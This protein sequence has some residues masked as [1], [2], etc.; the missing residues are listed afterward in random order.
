MD[1]KNVVSLIFLNPPLEFCKVTQEIKILMLKGGWKLYRNKE[2][3]LY[4]APHRASS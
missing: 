3:A 4:A 1:E 2:A